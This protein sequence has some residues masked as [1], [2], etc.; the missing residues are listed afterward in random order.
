METHIFLSL[1]SIL[2]VACQVASFSISTRHERSTD[3]AEA[4][5]ILQRQRRRAVTDYL[6]SDRLL[7]NEPY[8]LAEDADWLRAADVGGG[9]SRNPLDT[10]WESNGRFIDLPAPIEYDI[11]MDRNRVSVPVAIEPSKQELEDIFEAEDADENISQPKDNPRD[12]LEKKKKEEMLS[13][14]GDGKVVQKKS[15]SPVVEEAVVVSP[16]KDADS[17]DGISLDTLTKDEFHALMKAVDKLQ[18]QAVKFSEKTI[19]TPEATVTKVEAVQSN[20]DPKAITIVQPA[21]KEEL[22]AVFDGEET[23]VVKETEVIVEREPNA[24][25][26]RI[27]EQQVMSN[28]SPNK[29]KELKEK[30]LDLINVIAS[31]LEDNIEAE[32]E[33][34][35]DDED[36]LNDENVN[37][38]GRRNIVGIE[39]QW[40]NR[41]YQN[42]THKRT[43][44]R[45]A[46]FQPA[47]S[48]PFNADELAAEISA[49]ND[50]VLDDLDI[51]VIPPNLERFVAKILELQDQV[52]NL[53]IVSRLEDL[54]NDVLT[55][56]L[57]EATLAQKEG[58]V[59]DMEFESLQQA[60]RIEEALQKL[61]NGDSSKEYPDEELKRGEPWR[62]KRGQDFDNTDAVIYPL[63]Q[64]SSYSVIPES[65]TELSPLVNDLQGIILEP[66]ARQETDPDADV[67][68][69]F[70]SNA[71]ECPAVQ[72]YST[73]C[74]LADLYSLPVD[75]EARSLCN[76]HEMCY[77]CGKSLQV[78]QDQCDLVYRAAASALCRGKENC[79]VES[80]IFLRTLKLKNR[81]I[82][83][84]QPLCR[85]TC[86]AQ[87]LGML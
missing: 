34:E 56:A 33:K 22:K 11:P 20:G 15:F 48:P 38:A 78:G 28:L 68:S 67:A 16:A 63:E 71:D 35:S 61:K 26:E 59:T 25:G 40:L 13:V 83:H 43:I 66:S 62:R 69:F 31:E 86:V 53:K 5:A 10:E 36:I 79:V 70:M 37:E 42:P 32:N 73:N 65:E 23:P 2:L 60:I 82:P 55:D 47:Q 81:Y 19:E 21:S 76:L 41:K 27:I 58:S 77:A 50:D 54:E 87:F 52:D 80:E 14:K 46:A 39:K 8:T 72:E 4:L 12:L 30:E 29:A 24:S 74:E 51:A 44:K 7:T 49:N 1:L 57:N 3:L 84:S 18:K 6:G 45:A 75:F 17:N 9:N 85:S 64:P